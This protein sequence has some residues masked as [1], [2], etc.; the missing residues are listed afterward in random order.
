MS[1]AKE[2]KTAEG[3]FNSAE[4]LNEEPPSLIEVAALSEAEI[5]PVARSSQKL[6]SRQSDSMVSGL[7]P[8]GSEVRLAPQ[9]SHLKDLDKVSVVSLDEAM[10]EEILDIVD[11]RKK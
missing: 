6:A 9:L 5:I 4:N 11:E 2:N 1:H 10:D 8:S 3:F 7:G